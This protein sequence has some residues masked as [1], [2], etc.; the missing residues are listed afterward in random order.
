MV[1]RSCRLPDHREG[2]GKDESALSKDE[3]EPE[4]DNNRV[5][6]HSAI[7]V[8]PKIGLRQRDA[9]VKGAG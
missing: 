2:D 4:F 6:I 9:L 3:A 7:H 1:P 8:G 5:I